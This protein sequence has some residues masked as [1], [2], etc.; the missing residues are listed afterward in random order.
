[1]TGSRVC[2]EICVVSS[3]KWFAKRL[4]C[5]QQETDVAAYV[6]DSLNRCLESAGLSADSG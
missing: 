6:C 5:V 4:A 2:V 3:W 1:M